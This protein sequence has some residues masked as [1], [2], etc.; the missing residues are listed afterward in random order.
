MKM[1]MYVNV[2]SIG[3]KGVNNPHSNG[4]EL[5]KGP[6]FVGFFI[7]GMMCRFVYNCAQHNTH[8]IFKGMIICFTKI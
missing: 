6:I 8:K 2:V 7:C 3:G 1:E 5:S 4:L